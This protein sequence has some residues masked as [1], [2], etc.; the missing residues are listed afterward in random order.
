LSNTLDG[1]RDQFDPA[2]PF[3]VARSNG[4]R[5]QDIVE[6]ARYIEAVGDCLR[7]RLGTGGVDRDAP[8]RV[9]PETPPDETVGTEV[10]R[11]RAG[12][13]R[14]VRPTEARAISTAC[15]EVHPV[16]AGR[17][18]RLDDPE[19]LIKQDVVGAWL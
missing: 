9:D 7:R 6:G 3:G 16:A 4:D 2:T 14:N 13:V 1:W 17:T 19:S 11:P 12:H 10:E 5:W 18:E 8:S 15:H